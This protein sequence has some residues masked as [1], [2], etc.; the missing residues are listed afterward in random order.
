MTSEIT[1][2]TDVLIDQLVS[3][4]EPRNQ[5]KF[6]DTLQSIV[7]MARA[8]GRLEATNTALAFQAALT[9]RSLH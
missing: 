7:L 1:M 3:I 4:Q 5:Q 6:R 9:T 8:E 2:G